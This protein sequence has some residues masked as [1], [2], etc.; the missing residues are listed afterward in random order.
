MRIM[1]TGASGFVG[2]QV[3]TSLAD[4]GETVIAVSRRPPA[5]G[6]QA[7]WLRADLLSE[8]TAAE[9]VAAA[10]PD[11]I[12][13]LAWIVEHGTFWTSPLNLAWIA[14]SLRLAQAAA[15]NGVKRFVATGT[16]YEY[17]W[18]DASDCEED[19][20]PIAPSTLYGVSKD[21]TRRVLSAY[22][23][24]RGLSFAWARL[25]FLYGPGEGPN[26][27]VPSICRSLV[28]EAPAPCSRGLAVRDFM[29]VRDASAGIADLALSAVNG[30]INIAAS[31]AVSV[32]DVA[33]RLGRL[34]GRPDLIRLG[35]LPDR[36]GEPP[37]ITATGAR[38]LQA[39][40]FRPRFSL[41]AGL[42]DALQ[43]WRN[44]APGGTAA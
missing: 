6:R 43:Y 20:T 15:E 13:H 7:T 14:A 37:R 12:V 44:S 23:H 5:G 35:D 41:D 42:S 38:L 22:L 24:E 32:A 11:V 18:P 4:K 9:T 3:I 28:A 40:G 27:L 19:A 29:D 21:A 34:A 10:R 39:T 16:C 1:V 26:R 17:A 31:E 36:L 30:S 2:R 25:F 33:L 8:G